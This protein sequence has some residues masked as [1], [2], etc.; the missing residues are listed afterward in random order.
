[1]EIIRSS[2]DLTKK[3]IYVLSC[4]D[5]SIA[6]K[7]AAGKRIRPT[8]WAQYKDVDKEGMEREILTIMD[9]NGTIYGG[10]SPTF[11]RKFLE[12]VDMLGEEL[13]EI[14]VVSGMSRSGKAFTSC[15][16]VL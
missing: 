6:F 2:R 11:A 15:R 16:A 10:N 9:E 12:A 8:I 3:E 14:E 4:T 7:D 13:T 5:G 1:M